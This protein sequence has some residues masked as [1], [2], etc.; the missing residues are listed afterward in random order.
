MHV[1]ANS[2]QSMEL[3]RLR[4]S[5]SALGVNSI[6]ITKRKYAEKSL[7]RLSQAIDTLSARRSLYGAMENRLKHISSNNQNTS[8]NVQAS[9]SIVRDTDFSTEMVDYSKNNILFQVT[10]S[11]L[12]QANQTPTRI[13]DLLHQL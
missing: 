7:E 6:T 5:S 9:E 8:E 10:Q 2:K 13:L 4:V 11:V 3:P 1:G 12:A